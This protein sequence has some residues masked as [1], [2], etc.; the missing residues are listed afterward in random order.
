MPDGNKNVTYL[1]KP[2][3]FSCRF[4]YVCVTFLLPPGIKGLKYRKLS[5]FPVIVT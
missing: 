3:A 1:N 4:V 2:E 5:K